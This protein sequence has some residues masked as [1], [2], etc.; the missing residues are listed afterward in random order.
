M[1]SGAWDTLTVGGEE[2]DIDIFDTPVPTE[3][4]PT[5]ATLFVGPPTAPQ[6]LSGTTGPQ[7][8]ETE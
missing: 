2:V 4:S 6:E 8:V 3:P 7:P 1:V 5:D